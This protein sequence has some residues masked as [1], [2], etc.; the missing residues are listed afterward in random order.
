MR[1]VDRRLTFWMAGYY[2]DF[3]G[4]VALPDDLNEPAV[5]YSSTKSHAGNA[6]TGYAPLN[7]RHTFA[8]VEREDG[9]TGRFNNFTL[10]GGA[11]YKANA[12][13]HE[14]LSYDKNRRNAGTYDGKAQ[15]QSPDSITNANRQK[16]KAGADYATV[17]EGYLMFCNGYDTSKRYFAATGTNDATFGRDNAGT[18][19]VNSARDLDSD[20]GIPATASTPTKHIRTHLA[21][22]YSGEVLYHDVISLSNPYKMLYP[23]HSPSGGNFLVNEIYTTSAS[24][25]PVLAYDGTL[26]SKGDGD[27]FTIRIHAAAVDT[28]SARIKLRI[29]CEGT[30]MTSTVSG[31]TTYT[32]AAIEYEITPVAYQEFTGSYSAPTLTSLWDDYDFII[33][34][35]ASTY[36]IYKN[37]A[38]VSTGNS[39]S[40]KASGDAF[41]AADMYGWAMEAKNCS[42][43]ATVLI[44]RVGVIRPLNDHPAG[45][46]MPPA[47]KMTWNSTVNST[48]SLNLTLIDDDAQLKLLSFFN[49]SSYSDWGLLMFRDNIARPLW[50]GFVTGL[51]YSQTASSSTPTITI[52][53]NDS[54][55]NL[56]HQ[57]PVWELGTGGDADSTSAVAY[58]RSEAQNNLNLYYFGATRMVTSNATLSFNEYEDGS[59]VFVEHKDSRMR[60]RSAHPIQMYLGEDS[61]GPNASYADWD[62]A[63]T[64]G[65]ATSD[66][67]ARSIHSRWIKDIKLSNW[68]KHT[69]G[70][71]EEE[72]LFTTTLASNFTKGSTAMVLT[73]AMTPITTGTSIEIIDANGIVDSGIITS[74]TAATNITPVSIGW[75]YTQVKVNNRRLHKFEPRIYVNQSHISFSDFNK[76]VSISGSV[77]PEIN[78][79]FVIK[80]TGATKTISGTACY[81]LSLKQTNGVTDAA[82][83]TSFTPAT[84][85]VD[86][87]YTPT[88]I[89][90]GVSGPSSG[91]AW[92]I[93]GVPQSIANYQV[94]VFFLSPTGTLM[95]KGNTTCAL[96]ATNFFQRDHAAGETVNIR[97]VS[98]DFK[99]IWVLW[100]DMRND[101]NANADAGLRRS[102]FGLMTPYAS[103]HSV[104]LVYADQDTSAEDS[105]QE[106]VDL[107][108]GQDVDLWEMDAMA[109]PL[110]G[111]KW[112]AV[113]GGSD[114]ESNSKYHDWWNK[115]GSFVIIDTSKFFN[116][117]TYTNSGM[118][119]QIAGGRK[120]IGDYLVETEGFPVLIDNYWEKAP[121]T[122][123][124]LIDVAWNSNYKYFLSKPTTLK[125]GVEANDAVIQVHEDIIPDSVFGTYPSFTPTS[126]QLVSQEKGKKYHAAINNKWPAVAT[127]GVAAASGGAGLV[128]LTTATNEG[129]RFRAGHTITISSST[130]TPTINGEYIIDSRV[131]NSTFPHFSDSLTIKID[132]LVT[133]SGAGTCTITA[134]N[135][136]TLKTLGFLGKPVD[137]TTASGEWDG[138]DYGGANSADVLIQA[139]TTNDALVSVPID[140]DDSNAMGDLQVHWGLAN[141][142]PMRLMMQVNGFVE[143]PA[144]MTF[145]EHDKFRV[146]YMDS[147]TRN[148]MQ[149]SALYGIPSIATIPV[150]NE[151]TTSQKSI[152][153]V[154]S[155]GYIGLTGAGTNSAINTEDAAGNPVPH[156]LLVGDKVTIIGNAQFAN[157]PDSDYRQDYTITA[158]SG[159]T[160][161]SIDNS[162]SASATNNDGIWRKAGEV[163]TFGSVNNARNATVASIFTTTQSSAGISDTYGVRSP[164]VWLSGRDGRP[165][166]RPSYASGFVFNRNNLTVSTL[167]SQSSTQISNVRVFY[168]GGVAFVDYP[169]ASLGSR[170]RWDIMQVPEVTSAAEALKVA[171]Q[172]YE[173]NKDAPLSITA[174]IQRLSDAHNMGGTNDT[175]LYN[176]R[177]GYIADQ[178][179]TV[180][181]SRGFSSGTNTED[182]A[183]AWFS[184]YG[185][186]LFGGVTNALDGKAIDSA[187]LSST[188]AAWNLNYFWYGSHS[189]S[190]A[191]QVVDVPHG[192]PKTTDKTA[193]GSDINGDGHLRF[194]IDIDDRNDFN[195]TKNARF[196]VYLLDY[197][198]DNATYE[199][200]LRSSSSITVDANGFYELPVPST[201]WA[202]QTGDERVIISVNYDYLVALLDNRCGP[203]NRHKNA[204]NWAVSYS[205][206]NTN[207]I[208]PLGV[209]KWGTA[210]YW[211]LRSEWYAPRLHVVDDVNFTV[212]T[213]LDY[214]DSA[215]ELSNEALQIRSISWGIDG[216]NREDLS[217]TLER[218]MSRAARGGFANFLLPKT[219]KSPSTGGGSG[220]GGDAG[221]ANGGPAK[222]PDD[223]FPD[224][225]QWGGYGD[226]GDGLAGS[227]GNAKFNTVSNPQRNF[228]SPDGLTSNSNAK[229]NIGANNMAGNLTNAI[230]GVMEFNT[231]SMTGGT[232]AVLG[233]KK[234]SAPPRNSDGAYGLTMSPS[235]GDAVTDD[236]GITFAGATDTTY[237]HSAFNTNVPVPPKV[238][239]DRIEISGRLTMGAASGNAV[240]F[241]TASVLES[242]IE[243]TSETTVAAVQKGN[244]VFFNDSVEGAN[245]NSNTLKITIAR[246]AGVGSDTA[247]YGSVT[248][249]NL[250]VGFDTQSVSGSGE[251]SQLS[252]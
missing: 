47:T 21:G 147:L 166:F 246:Q 12:G 239:T 125:V 118:T 202:A 126:I 36:D 5:T 157:D 15:I 44:D 247:Q 223:G 133:L 108:V 164:F 216:Q 175:M 2:D 54:Y 228:G 82:I 103:N 178:S 97:V 78:G 158:L 217:L 213:G 122:P 195:I 237:P 139:T 245:I 211:N 197:D 142:F 240:I 70:K 101:G 200:A 161:F 48:S 6:I 81:E 26:N 129:K 212:G 59:G 62:A 150:T 55:K 174:Q 96:P 144:S 151:M 170:P 57:I 3:M 183:W 37:G 124:N 104:S 130:T 193:S 73:D 128:T 204:H 172:E 134:E 111:L 250:Q 19:D 220:S 10:T 83:L 66:A 76:I 127:T 227:L 93:L 90:T 74:A 8:W 209:R 132:P 199:G 30:A 29:G 131:A 137:G 16:Y 241:V 226:W 89:P 163:D 165:S 140:E 86:V 18:P 180:P 116:L 99:H 252:Y 51:S 94:Y 194:A 145:A 60:N 117:N 232:F 169:S 222:K 61:R 135:T 224:G 58:N 138:T 45:T 149:Q 136:Y 39:M 181:Y 187:Y 68:F 188:N 201:Y 49:Q 141:V 110:T 171:R 155:G 205:S 230:K 65:H 98:D 79:S 50:R 251:S 69:F 20:A 198:W 17:V 153:S 235:S 229:F 159:A 203:L 189:L 167:K 53:A 177:F 191:L 182:K 91:P 100:S 162:F 105:R 233:Q 249:H 123:F 46:E 219:P 242:G 56:E 207:S 152:V 75:A 218:D 32:N 9:A 41:T 7:P 114:A 25:D 63:V 92:A 1:S 210:D 236:N 95:V 107:A 192:M 72:P 221:G 115:A 148:W 176:A 88:N 84:G 244:V 28:S 106:F 67:A 231:D 113:A 77:I 243:V 85:N 196:R 102:K 214:T 119:G 38:S 190:Y 42:K 71:I 87:V 23:I 234:P 238:A 13:I 52:T 64:A 14:W 112:S 43:K 168:N 34:Y 120:E 4:A 109:D 206:F 33:N 146:T 27:I 11:Q 173:K 208:F 248:I 40:N 22:V 156:G 186:N 179:R 143:N 185:G 184:L 24:Y 154:G 160:Q 215:L 31:E 225:G 35:T 80:S 121:T